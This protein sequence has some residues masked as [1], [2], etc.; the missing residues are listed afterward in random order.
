MANTGRASISPSSRTISQNPRGTYFLIFGVL[1]LG[2][3]LTNLFAPLH[4]FFHVMASDGP[5]SFAGWSSSN[6]DIR[7]F[8]AMVTAGW[9][10]ELIAFALFTIVAIRAGKR[11]PIFTGGFPIGYMA[12]TWARGFGSYDF[13]TSLVTHVN[14]YTQYSQILRD[15]AIESYSARVLITWAALGI[16]FIG[17]GLALAWWNIKR[18]RPR[19]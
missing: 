19:K 11:F 8:G 18:K 17:A 12:T 15:R 2:I 16:V 9:Y 14:S 10:G 6:V 1:G 5:S 4:E 13:T 3:G 7:D